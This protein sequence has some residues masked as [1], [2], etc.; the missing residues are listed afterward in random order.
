M[1]AD[2]RDPDRLNIQLEIVYNI[3]LGISFLRIKI[4]NT[5]LFRRS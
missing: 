1:S 2:N 5:G 3:T 4:E